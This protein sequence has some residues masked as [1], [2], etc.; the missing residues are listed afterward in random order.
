MLRIF[1]DPL[2]HGTIDRIPQIDVAKGKLRKDF[3][4]ALNAQQAIG[5]MHK[6][7]REFLQRQPRIK[8]EEVIERLI[9]KDRRAQTRRFYAILFS[10]CESRGEAEG[11]LTTSKRDKERVTT[12]T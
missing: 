5:M 12:R 2:Y 4:M 7:R 9:A 3:Y 1:S 8:P 6:K 11:P 10:A